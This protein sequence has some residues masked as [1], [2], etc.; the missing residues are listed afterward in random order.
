MLCASI[1]VS[2]EIKRRTRIGAL[3][4][5]AYTATRPYVCM[6]SRVSRTPGNRYV[7]FSELRLT[8]QVRFTKYFLSTRSCPR[9]N[10]RTRKTIEY[11]NN[12]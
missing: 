10:V 12:D 1:G 8:I 9:A 3:V 11:G 2:R 5:H 6:R 7:A 4:A